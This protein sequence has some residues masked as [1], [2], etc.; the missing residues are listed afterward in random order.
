MNSKQA[1]MIAEFVGRLAIFCVAM[2]LAAVLFICPAW[3]LKIPLK[4]NNGIA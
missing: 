1:M 3:A 2:G 4:Q